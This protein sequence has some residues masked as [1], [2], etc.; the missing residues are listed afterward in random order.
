MWI[1]AA[2]IVLATIGAVF[3]VRHERGTRG[4]DDSVVTAASQPP[5]KENA[6]GVDRNVQQVLP[7]GESGPVAHDRQK[8]PAEHPFEF[9]RD[10]AA[11]AYAG[12]AD[13]QYRIAKE[14]DRCDM[15]LSLV[16]KSSDP[17]ADIWNLPADWSQG[18]KDMTFSEYHRCSRL[19][20]EDPFAGLP[21]R[22][23]GYTAG[24]WKARAAESGQ[25]LALVEKAFVTLASSPEDAEKSATASKEAHA[26]LQKAILSGNPDALLL[27]GFNMRASGYPERSLQGAAWMLAACRAGAD[28]GFD[29]AIFPFWMCSGDP[30]C[31]PGADVETML[32]TALSSA[33]FAQASARYER[34]MAALRARDGEAINA[35]LGF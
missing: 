9:I 32:S 23:G 1:A 31:Q 26:M 10:L 4:V 8:F 28:C 17:E 7:H 24:Y 34:I 16:R 21:S 12:D 11:K 22:A 30:R 25:P 27:L 18:M 13:A 29:S 33:D 20:R 5:S 3:A 15:T 35:Q 6:K 2:L 14:L 19:L